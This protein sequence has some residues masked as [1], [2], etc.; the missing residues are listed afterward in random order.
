M[1]H[2]PITVAVVS[3]FNPGENLLHSCTALLQQCADVIVVDDGS[4]APDEDVFDAVASLGCIVL[5]LPANVGIAA[6][7]N[8]GTDL[9]RERHQFLDF[10]LT[11]DQDSLVEPGFVR[12]LARAAAAAQSVDVN[13]GMV[14]PGTVSGLPSRARRSVRNVVIGDEP[15]QSGLL[16]PAATLDAIGNFNEALFIDGVDSEF[17]LRAKAAG[18]N[19]II[20]PE[21]SL[22]H[23]LGTMAPASIGPWTLKWRGTPVMV[24]TAADWRYYFIVRNRILLGRKFAFRE[25]YWVV[26]GFLTDARHILVVTLL[27]AGR[28]QRLSS[29]AMGLAAGLRGSTGPRRSP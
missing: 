3:A 7:L 24:R 9:A 18:L 23:S 8:R 6:A 1:E 26:R 20:A 12:E 10:I 5:R 2:E 19:C 15:V 25:P 28:R 21:A 29:A 11:M 4:S 17:Y 16:I 22:T 13:V 14:A 27:S